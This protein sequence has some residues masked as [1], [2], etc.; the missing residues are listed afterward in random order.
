MDDNNVTNNKM[1][2]LTET[3]VAVDDPEYL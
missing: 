2:T 1:F 3:A